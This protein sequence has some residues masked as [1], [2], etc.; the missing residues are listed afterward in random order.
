MRARAQPHDRIFSRRRRHAKALAG[1]WLR[2]GDEGL[3]RRRG[4]ER[5]FFITPGRIKE[6]IIRNGEKYS[7]LGIERK[8]L[9]ALPE[10]DGKLIVLGFPHQL[11]GEEVGAYVELSTLEGCARGSKRPPRRCAV[12]CAGPRS[13]CTA[14]RRFPRTHTGKIQRKK[15]LPAFAAFESCRGK[16]RIIAA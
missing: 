5:V 2:T 14:P 8:L 11:H 16:L 7:P 13:S 3:F 9:A 15:L 6:L 1:D 4:D 10:L 12:E